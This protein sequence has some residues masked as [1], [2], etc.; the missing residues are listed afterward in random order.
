MGLLY[1]MKQQTLPYEMHHGDC[2]QILQNL[3]DASVDAIIT[4]PPYSSGGAFRSDRMGKTTEKYTL[5]GTKVKRPAFSG[6]NRDQRSFAFWCTLWLQ[7]CYRVAKEGAPICVFTDWR[8]LPI[9][10][11]V[12]QAAGFVWRGVPVWDKT[13][14]CRPIKGR[15]A[16]QSEFIV[17]GSKG[18]MPVERGVGCLAGVFPIVVKQA[19]KFHIT[20]KPVE[21]M[22]RLIEVTKPGDIVLDPFAGSGSTGVAAIQTGRRFIGIEMEQ[23]YFDIA[24]HRLS[25]NV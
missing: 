8:Q 6:D 18:P 17:F 19:D 11:D 22:K 14:A 10:T 25:Q 5:G 4:D 3:P 21:L 12:F 1:L 9:T 2:L 20:G 24:N 7:E 13:P 16:H 23:S 15:F